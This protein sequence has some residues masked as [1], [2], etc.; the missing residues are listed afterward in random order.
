MRWMTWIWAQTAMRCRLGR[1]TWLGSASFSMPNRS[2]RKCRALPLFLLLGLEAGL[3]GLE[4][5]LV[6]VLVVW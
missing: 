3:E 6:Q 5:G 2:W 4:A 1:S